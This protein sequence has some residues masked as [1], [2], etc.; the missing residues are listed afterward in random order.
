PIYHWVDGSM[1]TI[2]FNASIDFFQFG[3]MITATTPLPLPVR[4]A[5]CEGL[6]VSGARKIRSSV[7]WEV[8]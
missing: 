6:L 4:S 1:M 2:N 8:K 3:A 5:P 7:A